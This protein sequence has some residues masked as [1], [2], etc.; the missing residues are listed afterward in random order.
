MQS[1][2]DDIV[3]SLMLRY[4]GIFFSD[5]ASAYPYEPV[6]GDGTNTIIRERFLSSGQKD[7][8]K[9]RSWTRRASF[10]STPL[11]ESFPNGP[12]NGWRTPCYYAFMK[13]MCIS[14][15]FR[16]GNW[17]EIVLIVIN[18]ATNTVKFF[19]HDKKDHRQTLRSRRHSDA[20]Y[21]TLNCS[22]IKG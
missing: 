13:I 14:S 3:K 1:V 18:H 2:K 17:T 5:F 22:C 9:R 20:P 8:P 6:S 11:G 7:E 19:S 15:T 4:V 21:C 12:S 10:Y 16:V